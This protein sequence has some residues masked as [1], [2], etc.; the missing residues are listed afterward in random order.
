[1]C[2]SYMSIVQGDV[3]GFLIDVTDVH[4]QNIDEAETGQET[5]V[6]GN[7]SKHRPCTDRFQLCQHYPQSP[8]IV[9]SEQSI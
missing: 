2:C 8:S 9:R 6:T 7:R 5:I 4:N 1:M 3:G